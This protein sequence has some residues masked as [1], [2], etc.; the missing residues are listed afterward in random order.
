MRVGPN[1]M[2]TILI[3]TGDRESQQIED[4]E[5][6]Q[7]EVELMQLQGKHKYIPKYAFV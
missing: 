6:T 7:A 4:L 2:T 3:K 5:V 1:L